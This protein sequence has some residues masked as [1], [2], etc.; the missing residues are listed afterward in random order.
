MT[1]ETDIRLNP[2]GILDRNGV[3]RYS[4]PATYTKMANGLYV[5]YR[6]R[7]F[8]VMFADGEAFVPDGSW[9]QANQSDGPDLSAYN[10]VAMLGQ[11]AAEDL[12]QG[13]VDSDSQYRLILH[14]FGQDVQFRATFENDGL[15]ITATCST[16]RNWYKAEAQDGLASLAPRLDNVY[17]ECIDDGT[18]PEVRGFLLEEAVM[19]TGDA[20]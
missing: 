3:I 4:H 20:A 2:R 14:V 16:T 8:G 6:R 7:I 18:T 12:G 11:T 17:F 15:V 9:G 1:I 19:D 13:R 10:C 5:K